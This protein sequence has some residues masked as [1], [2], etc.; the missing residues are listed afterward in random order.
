M[1]KT[2]HSVDCQRVFKNYDPSCPRCNE[3]ASGSPARKGWYSRK[4]EDIK[5]AGRISTHFASL[6]HRTGK[7]EIVCTWGE[8]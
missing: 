3:L 5:Q 2:K 7:C 1:A 8:W 6:E 4:A